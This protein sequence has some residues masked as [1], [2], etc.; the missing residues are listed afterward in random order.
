MPGKAAKVVITERQQSVLQ[1]IA[2]ART[3]EVRMSQRARIILLAFEGLKNEE[4]SAQVS[5]NPDQVGVWRKRWKAAF[6]QLVSV[7]CTEPRDGLRKAILAVLADEHRSGRPARITAEQQAQLVALACEQPNPDE[8]PVSHRS[9]E[10]LA[11]EA[12]KRGIVDSISARH[13][14]DILERNDVRPHRHKYWL[15]SPDRRDPDFGERVT[16]ICDLYQEA[17]E[18][19]Q[20]KG[21]HTVCIDEQTGIQALERIAPDLPTRPGLTAKLEFEYR[22]HGTISLFGNLHVPTGQILKPLLNAT[23]TEE[24]FLENLDNL[25]SHDEDAQWRLIVDN[26]NTHCSES[27]VLYVAA[28]CGLDDDLGEKGVR[29]VLKNRFTRMKFLS[30]PTHRIRFIYL[31]RHTSWL[32][33]IEIWF[34]LLRRKVTRLGNFA[35]LPHLCDKITQFITYYNSVLAHPYKWTY[36]GRLLCK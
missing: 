17:Q 28:A 1:E 24:D 2:A 26:L 5:M 4:V 35:S 33:Q 11:G 6:T 9:S 7:E 36:K 12:V 13:L 10:D 14:R 20:Q 30:D 31:P 16:E 8:C 27:C 29:G 15:T 3:S 22:R 23:R 18:L 19:Y 25:I 34:G 32:N 21:I